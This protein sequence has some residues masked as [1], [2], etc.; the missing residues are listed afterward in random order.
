MKSLLKVILPEK[1]TARLALIRTYPAYLGRSLRPDTPF[2]A[3]FFYHFMRILNYGDFVKR[4]K[5]GSEL[6]KKSD[7]EIMVD[8]G[9][10]VV[11]TRE[12]AAAK[13]CVE[14]CLKVC[15]GIDFE[16]LRAIAKK[17]FLL[18]YPLDPQDKSHSP[19]FEYALDTQILGAI[20]GYIGSLPTLLTVQLW[21]SN[22]NDEDGRSQYYHFDAEDRR[23]V[24][25]FLLLD[26]IDEETRP[27]TLIPAKQSQTIYHRLRDKGLV[28]LR[29][30]KLD[31]E[32]IYA[33]SDCDEG[34]KMLGKKGMSVM[35][36]PIRC[37]H[38]GS[39]TGTKRRLILMLQYLSAYTV[40][41][42]VWG[43]NQKKMD[44]SLDPAIV[45]PEVVQMTLGL[46][47]LNF[48]CLKRK[49]WP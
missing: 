2:W 43:R 44:L 29:N 42:P 11:D 45:S 24:R 14:H 5:I 48:T 1:W 22:G 49:T 34:M 39:R 8:D 6:Q 9:F 47:H 32:L 25:V 26:D 37:Y 16:S 7:L 10:L 4:R 33:H 27:F 28:K 40:E 13:K 46:S 30:V 31:D 19:I 20:S 23:T 41:L 17:P 38:Y 3:S 36:D 12:N 21:Y 18:T 15:K 35:A